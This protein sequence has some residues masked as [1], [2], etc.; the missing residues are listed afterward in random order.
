MSDPAS[1]KHRGSSLPGRL[2]QPKQVFS[3]QG[4]NRYTYERAFETVSDRLLTGVAPQT[5]TDEARIPE[6]VRQSITPETTRGEVIA[7]ALVAGAM[8]G[9]DRPQPEILKRLWPATRQHGGS[10]LHENP[11]TMAPP[12]LSKLTD[13]ER[14]EARRLAAKALMTG[15]DGGETQA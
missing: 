4:I 14:A 11:M 7:R 15:S 1:D 12:D 9:R 3:P 5:K 6:P 10:G 13:A 8:A 2:V